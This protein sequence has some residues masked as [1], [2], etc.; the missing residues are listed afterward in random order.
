MAG[1]GENNLAVGGRWHILQR[2]CLLAEQSSL[3]TLADNAFL[4]EGKGELSAT[5]P[6]P[7]P[8]RCSSEPSEIR[9]GDPLSLESYFTFG[10]TRHSLRV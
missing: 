5:S 9:R 7:R 10:E 2:V 4:G 3:F 1:L 6:P 8:P